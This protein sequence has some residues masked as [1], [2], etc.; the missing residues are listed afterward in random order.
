MS[1][2]R[3]ELWKCSNLDWVF[4]LRLR[5]KVMSR[6]RKYLKLFWRR[7]NIKILENINRIKLKVKRKRESKLSNSKITIAVNKFSIN[8]YLFL[9]LVWFLLVCHSI[10]QIHYSKGINIVFMEII[11]NNLYQIIH[12]KKLVKKVTNFG[13]STFP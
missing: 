10:S 5:L 3:K 13:L 7:F 2:K 1:V 4:S 11:L 8:I 6:F 12:I 9:S